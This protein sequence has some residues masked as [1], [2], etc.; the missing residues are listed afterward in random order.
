MSEAML[1][2][3]DLAYVWFGAPVHAGRFLRLKMPK[4]PKPQKAAVSSVGKGGLIDNEGT[5][6]FFVNGLMLSIFFM[7]FNFGAESFL[8]FGMIVAG[9]IIQWK[10]NVTSRVV[11]KSGFN[12]RTLT[13]I[14]GGLILVLTINFL[15]SSVL[16]VAFMAPP[17]SPA[18]LAM[19]AQFSN[20]P[21]Y[22]YTFMFAIAE[23][24]LFRAVLLFLILSWVG[25]E[26]AAIG[27]AAF[28]W[29]IYHL[30]VYGAQPLVLGFVFFTGLVLGY[31]TVQTRN[32]LASTCIHGVNN[33]VATGLMVMKM[34]G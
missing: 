27:G 14:A 21:V 33:L 34:V 25:N 7:I 26:F 31:I 6:F 4:V 15:F 16:D 32:I 10:F 28:A 9:A 13:F 3:P 20:F 17:I 12:V 22:M 29:M 5:L 8:P 18:A 19:S 11:K 30:L 2:E 23:E 24:Y 1:R